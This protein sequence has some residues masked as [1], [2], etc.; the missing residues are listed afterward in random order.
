MRRVTVQ[1]TGIIQMSDG[2]RRP[3]P[4]SRNSTTDGAVG[5]AAQAATL[6]ATMMSR[7]SSSSEDE[8]GV[9]KLRDHISPGTGDL[10]SKVL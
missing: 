10:V 8:D 4:P 5:G 9:A 3:V 6:N 7:L 1:D 2:Q